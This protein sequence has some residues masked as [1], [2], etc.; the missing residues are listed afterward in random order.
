MK[1]YSKKIKLF[2]LSLF[3]A[4]SY[5][6]GKVRNGHT[7]PSGET[8]DNQ[9]VE[10]SYRNPIEEQEVDPVIKKLNTLIAS[11]KEICND[12]KNTPFTDLN[13]KV[14]AF[15]PIFQEIESLSDHF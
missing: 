1:N 5:N 7:V 3:I 12:V 10:A 14:K 11:A 15:E 2:L 9:T 13:I 4:S 6:C 8:V